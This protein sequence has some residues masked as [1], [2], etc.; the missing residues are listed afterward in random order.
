MFDNKL[1]RNNE[2]IDNR[3]SHRRCF[4]MHSTVQLWRCTKQ[5]DKM[6]QLNRATK[7]DRKWFGMQ[8]CMLCADLSIVALNCY[9]NEHTQ[10]TIV[11]RCA[12]EQP[13]N[14][15]RNL[16]SCNAIVKTSFIV[17]FI[18]LTRLATVLRLKIC[19]A[20]LSCNTVLYI[21]EWVNYVTSLSIA[22][23]CIR[24]IYQCRCSLLS[25]FHIDIGPI[26][27]ATPFEWCAVVLVFVFVLYTLSVEPCAACI[28]AFGNSTQPP[29]SCHCYLLLTYVW[30]NAVG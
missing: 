5:A 21:G 23:L 26:C 28:S 24:F 20:V 16:Q 18:A 17:A 29:L 3:I 25:I 9:R 22:F 14:I 1:I 6:Y 30:L 4:Q 13:H 10:Q 19:V 7:S 12:T 2:Q 11:Q 8:A 15:A 27:H